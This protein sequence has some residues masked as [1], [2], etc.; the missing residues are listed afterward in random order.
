MNLLDFKLPE[1][2]GLDIAFPTLK[3]NKELLAEAKERG[4]YD[5]NTPYNKLFSEIF[6]GGGRVKFK[7]GIDEDFKKRA[8]AYCRAFMGSWEPKH[9]EKEAICAL[10]M[11]EILEPKLQPA[12]K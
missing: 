8:W 3:T 1:V 7:E 5:G 12:N 9:E 11:S 6:F 2:T 10:I 4:F